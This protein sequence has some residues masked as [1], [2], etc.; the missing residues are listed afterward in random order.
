[1]QFRNDAGAV[2]NNIC[3]LFLK[4]K[5]VSGLSVA[6]IHFMAPTDRA[7]RFDMCRAYLFSTTRALAAST[8]CGM[9][10]HAKGTGKS[11]CFTIRRIQLK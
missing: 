9:L 5:N 7:R 10:G 3:V 6:V 1:M 8:G 11:P 2:S 4:Q